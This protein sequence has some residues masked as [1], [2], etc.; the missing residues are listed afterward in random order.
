M[1]DKTREHVES[2]A[3]GN[4]GGV[5][6][7]QARTA[8]G[9]EYVLPV[10]SA[11][12]LSYGYIYVRT[13]YASFGID[14]HS[15]FTIQDYLTENIDNIYTLILPSIF[16]LFSVTWTLD[17]EIDFTATPRERDSYPKILDYIFY[18][19]IILTI[20]VIPDFDTS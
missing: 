14:V 4:G 2:P 5:K 11:L 9:K 6:A 15:F 13:Y 20:I 18:A 8:L 17:K 19:A 16:S 10:I 3:I 7:E 12:L 1:E